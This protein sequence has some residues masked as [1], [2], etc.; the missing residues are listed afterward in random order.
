MQTGCDPLANVFA[1]G[2]QCALRDAVPPLALPF[3][4]RL[5]FPLARKDLP[6]AI[7][8]SPT[9]FSMNNRTETDYRAMSIAT[10]LFFMWGF[11][12]SLNDILIPHLKSI[13]SL[14]NAQAALIQFAF[15]GSYFLFAVPGGKRVEYRG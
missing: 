3:S 4:H 11:L 10:T 5:G 13:F 2:A 9:A 7:S 1:A 15:F 12:T 14:T 8:S 6:M